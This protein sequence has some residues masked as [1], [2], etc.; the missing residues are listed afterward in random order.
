MSSKKYKIF[1]AVA[2]DT[3]NESFHLFSSK[4]S[5]LSVSAVDL[6][7]VLSL[8]SVIDLSSQVNPHAAT[9]AVVEH[10]C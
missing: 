2:L 1:G 5:T 9:A 6:F 7:L 10:A 3:F 8:E 4:H